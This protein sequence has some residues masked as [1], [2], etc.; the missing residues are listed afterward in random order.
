MA[1]SHSSSSTPNLLSA[2]GQ[3]QLNTDAPEENRS[4]GMALRNTP[5]NPQAAAGRTESDPSTR[6]VMAGMAGVEADMG[7]NESSTNRLVYTS[8]DLTKTAFKVLEELR[9]QNQLCDV[10]I[11][12]GSRECVAHRAV[13]AS[14]CPYF[15]GMFTGTVPNSL[16]G[17]VPIPVTEH[18][19]FF[20]LSCRK[21]A[22]R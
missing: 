2:T 22:R 12:V 1:S 21:E 7:I 16:I 10:T 15:R 5:R 17:S 14:T 8:K 3:G 19:V 4:Y 9:Q 18:S 6:T 11:K 20:Q 13:L